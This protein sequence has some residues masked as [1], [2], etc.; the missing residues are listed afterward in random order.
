MTWII[1]QTRR[2][3]FRWESVP[4]PQK[5]IS[6]FEEHTD[7]IKKGGRETVFGHKL[8][9]TGGASSL[10]LDCEVVGGNPANS[11]QFQPLLQR[12]LTAMAAGLDRSASIDAL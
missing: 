5:V 11:S 9:L 10:I 6:L 12:R 4:A 3:V 8:F 2:R 1:D 7:I